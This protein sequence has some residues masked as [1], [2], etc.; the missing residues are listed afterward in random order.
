[1]QLDPLKKLTSIDAKTAQETLA[2]ALRL[3]QE[4]GERVTIEELHRTA[5][6]AG[7]H[8]IYLEKALRRVTHRVPETLEGLLRRHVLAIVVT[9]TFATVTMVALNW[10]T[11]R[12]EWTEAWA[13]ILV[14]AAIGLSILLTRRGRRPISRLLRRQD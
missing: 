2:L 14:T 8:P 10:G 11:E 6:E 12:G 9:A 1:M 5:A 13:A 4:H 3:Q 7:I